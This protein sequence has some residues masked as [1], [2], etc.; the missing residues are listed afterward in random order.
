MNDQ[1]IKSFVE[2][3][4][5]S[6]NNKETNTFINLWKPYSKIVYNGTTY[7]DDNINEFLNTLY[8]QTMILAPTVKYSAMQNG[9]RRAN[10]LLTYDIIDQSNNIISFSQYILLAY[11][12]D[13]EYWIHSSLI[14]Q[15]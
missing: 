12:N 2:Y 15:K 11:S 8:Q 6:L 4:V 10:V 5:S 7:A 13:K 9:D 3:Y 14:N 1:I